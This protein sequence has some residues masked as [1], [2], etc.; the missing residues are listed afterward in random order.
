M[1]ISL[2]HCLKKA[3][4]QEQPEYNQ[5]EALLIEIMMKAI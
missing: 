4:T 1:T 3:G 5:K 2:M